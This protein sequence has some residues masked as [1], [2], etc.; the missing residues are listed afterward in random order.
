MEIGAEQFLSEP[1]VAP[2]FSFQ[3]AVCMF[4]ASCRAVPDRCPMC[5]GTTWDYVDWRPFTA[6]ALAE[7]E[8]DT[9]L[10]RD[11]AA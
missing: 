5:G 1:L 2:L 6:H 3:C 4:G 11:P 9:P 7:F 8:S 10:S